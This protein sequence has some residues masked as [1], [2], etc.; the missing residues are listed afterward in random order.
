MAFA[1]RKVTWD[2]AAL[3]EYAVAAL[4]RRMRSVAELKR[5]L[6]G[7]LAG[8]SG[9]E[10]L[11]EGVIGKLKDQHYLNDSQYAAA[12]ISY[13]RENEKFG[14]L[15]VITELKSRGIHGDII[16]N[17]VKEAYAGVNEEKLARQ[18]LAR[19]RI[20]KP[21]DGKAA[22]KTF[23]ALARAGFATPTIIAVLK[24][25]HVEDEILGLLEGEY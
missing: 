20:D 14:R 9:S 13:R 21:A 15:R 3:Y 12:Y 24:K 23:R 8:Q 6:R 25:W 1:R 7:R 17:S 22:A 16:T 4:A 11:V 10:A 5:L 2:Q 18:Y 19:K